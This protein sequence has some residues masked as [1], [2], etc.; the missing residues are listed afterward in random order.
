MDFK[1]I[2]PV[3]EHEFEQGEFDYDYDFN[4]LNFECPFCG[5]VGTDENV[6]TNEEDEEE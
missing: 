1:Y 5:W 3:C 2:C 6:E 4:V